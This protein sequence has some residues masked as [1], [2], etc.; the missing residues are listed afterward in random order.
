MYIRYNATGHC[1]KNCQIFRSTIESTV[2]DFCGHD[3]CEHVMVAIKVILEGM[4]ALPR[5]NDISHGAVELEER[6]RLYTKSKATSEEILR[7]KI[8]G[9]LIAPQVIVTNVFI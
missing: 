3:I 9:L 4:Q 7:P 1:A 2:C 8:S 6:K 5:D